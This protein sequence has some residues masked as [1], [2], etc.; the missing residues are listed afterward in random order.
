MTENNTPELTLDPTATAVEM[1]SL[2]LT[3]D[4]PEVPKVEEKR[5]NR[6]IWTRIC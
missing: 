6:S 3:P 1:P 5:S 2:T 4:A